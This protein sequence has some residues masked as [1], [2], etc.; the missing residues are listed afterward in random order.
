MS[1]PTVD[2]YITKRLEYLDRLIYHHEC[3]I[4]EPNFEEQTECHE[5]HGERQALRKDAGRRRQALTV[6]GCSTYVI[7]VRGG[8]AAIVCLCCGLGSTNAGDIDER[9]CGFCQ[10][11]HSDAMP[12]DQVNN[13]PSISN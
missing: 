7:G 3:N 10:T 2:Q 12:E 13:H 4:P 1:N 9:Y 8:V 6:S 5:A 11:W